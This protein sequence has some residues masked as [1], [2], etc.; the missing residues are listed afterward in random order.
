MAVE[1]EVLE[2]LR[3]WAKSLSDA[4]LSGRHARGCKFELRLLGKYNEDN[5]SSERFN[6]SRACVSSASA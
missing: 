1:V 5:S 3:L 2:R 4:A 6:G